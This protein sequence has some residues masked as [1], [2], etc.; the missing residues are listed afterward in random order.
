[1]KKQDDKI[2]AKLEEELNSSKYKFYKDSYKRFEDYVIINYQSKS[3]VDFNIPDD[4]MVCGIGTLVYRIRD[5]KVFEIF[6]YSNK[7]EQIKKILN[8]KHKK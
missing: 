1:M 8:D 2:L 3:I 4:N 5:E 6:S 7:E